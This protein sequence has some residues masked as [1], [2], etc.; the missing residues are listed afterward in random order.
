MAES[1]ERHPDFNI[2][3]TVSGDGRAVTGVVCEITLPEKYDASI[4]VRLLPTL[5]QYHGLQGLFAFDIAYDS[6]EGFRLTARDVQVDQNFNRSWSSGVTEQPIVAG[7]AWEL[8]VTRDTD[9]SLDDAN[10]IFRLTPNIYL[11]PSKNLI[12]SFTGE[13]VLKGQWRRAF[14]LAHCG[15][16]VFD[17]HYRFRSTSAGM[18]SRPYAVALCDL[19]EAITLAAGEGGAR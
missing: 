19:D 17:S 5:E 6:T 11:Q 10:T 8:T 12:H 15:W 4:G 16:T 1:E 9:S 2:P 18:L 13:V 3:V 7:H 14:P